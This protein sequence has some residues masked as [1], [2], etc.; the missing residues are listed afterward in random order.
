[1]EKISL[2]T[3]AGEQ[4]AAARTASNGRSAVPVATSGERLLQT[5]IALRAGEEMTEYGSPGDATVLVLTGRVRTG[6]GK[7]AVE[8]SNGDLLPVP[9]ASRDLEIVE[10]SVLLLSAV[11]R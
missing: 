6:S 1:M 7:S 4:L 10:D 9:E 8:A 3:V 2:R 11:R 5:V